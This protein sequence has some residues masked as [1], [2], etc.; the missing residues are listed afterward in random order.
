VTNKHLFFDLDR[1]L[2]DFDKNSKQALIQLFSDARLIDSPVSFEDFHNHYI[3]V[4]SDLW[5][6][7]GKKEITKEHL[8][9]ERF[10]KTLEKWKL[11]DDKLVSHFSDGYVEIS[12]KQTI[13]F[14]NTIETLEELKQNGYAMH[15]ITNGF[16]EVQFIKLENCKLR[17]YFDVIVCSEEIG[18]NKPAPEIFNYSMNKASTNPQNSTMIGDDYEVDI[19]GAERVGMRTFHFNPQI[20]E[21]QIK[22]LNQ[23][24]NLN[25]LPLKLVGL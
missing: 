4:N 19:L 3:Q 20:E 17:S 14:P 11:H 1:T 9:N 6:A 2:W 18:I 22:H 25:Q 8:R 23:I 12:P 13:L 16:K 21:K 7:Y 24:T 5:Q 15:I 10:R